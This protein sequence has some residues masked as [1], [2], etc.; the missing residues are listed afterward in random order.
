MHNLSRWS[1]HTAHSS[2]LQLQAWFPSLLT[3]MDDT[4]LS[5]R[6]ICSLCPTSVLPCSSFSWILTQPHFSMPSH[7]SF[8]TSP[9]SCRKGWCCHLKVCGGWGQ[10]TQEKHKVRLPHPWG[11]HKQTTLW[12]GFKQDIK[13]H[14][15]AL[16]RG[17]FHSY[18]HNNPHSKSRENPTT[19]CLFMKTCVD[20]LLQGPKL[21]CGGFLSSKKQQEKA[22]WCVPSTLWTVCK[23]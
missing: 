13:E 2:R 1:L 15:A 12:A 18:S 19:W 16:S 6:W 7:L 5:Q 9:A 20:V 3:E 4:D 22:A 8:Q 11:Y 23:I 21:S 10:G 17:C 14:R